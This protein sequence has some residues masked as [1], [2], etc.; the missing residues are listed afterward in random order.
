MLFKTRLRRLIAV[1][2]VLGVLTAVTPAAGLAQNIGGGPV[3]AR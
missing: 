3:P 2:L 1:G